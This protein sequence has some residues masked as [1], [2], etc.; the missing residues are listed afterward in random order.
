MRNALKFAIF[1]SIILISVS[2]SGQG[3]WWKNH[4]AKKLS[5]YHFNPETPLEDRV[6]KPPAFVVD[7]LSKLDFAIRM[8]HDNTK[9]FAPYRAYVP[10]DAE[11]AEVKGVIEKL[12]K[13][14]SEKIAPRLLGV[15]FVE[16]LLGSGL[17]EWV[18]GPDGTN[19]YFMVFNPKVLKLDASKW[20]TEKEN[21]NFRSDPAYKLEINIGTGVSGFYYIFYHELAHVYDYIE[22]VTPGEMNFNTAKKYVE[23]KNRGETDNTYPFIDKIWG[24]YSKPMPDFDFEGRDKIAFYGMN[25]GPNIEISD[26]P[27]LYGG[28]LQSPFVSLYGSMSWMEDFAEYAA[29]YMSVKKLGWPWTLTIEKDGG[30]IFE[31]KDILDRENTADRVKYIEDIMK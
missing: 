22:H 9:D 20:I 16:N 15:Y 17:S 8:G 12:P 5:S 3:A 21:S 6:A 28:L 2:C 31:M 26:A 11:L 18:P 25:G 19:Y 27:K 10:T 4:A 14:I 23:L 29:M 1:I 13:G 30:V 24:G 7:F